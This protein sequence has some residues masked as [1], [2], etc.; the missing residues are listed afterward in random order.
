MLTW[1]GRYRN[2]HNGVMDYG[3]INSQSR[4]AHNAVIH[5]AVM[6]V[7]GVKDYCHIF[8]QSHVA[9]NSVVQL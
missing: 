4:V 9:R 8:S 5:N 3:D 7:M 6:A 1:Y 2:F